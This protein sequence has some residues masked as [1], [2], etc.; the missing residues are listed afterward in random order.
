MEETRRIRLTMFEQEDMQRVHDCAMELLDRNGIGF[1]SDRAI[2]IFNEHGFR[3]D[4]QQVYFTE[5][6]VQAAL[7][8]C[9]SH[10]LLHGRNPKHT[11]DIGGGAYGVPGPIGPV[12][13]VSLDEDRHA[14]TFKDVENLIKIYQ[15]SDVINVNTNNGVEAN[16]IDASTRHFDIMK[17]VLKHS[18]KPFYTKCLDYDQLHQA[19][20][21]VEIATGEKL[22]PGGKTFLSSGSCPSL[23]PM[24]YS[25]EI[26]D[27]IIA[28]SERGQA[29]SFGNATTAGVTGPISIMGMTVMQTAELLSGIVL[30]QLVHPGT[31]VLFGTGAVPANMARATYCCGSPGRVAIELGVL[32]MGKRF[33]KLPARSIPFSTDST[34][35]DAQCLME[36]YEQL[37]GNTLGGADYMLSEIGTI[38]GLMT[39]SYEKTIL[40]EELVSRMLYIRDGI[41]VSLEACSVEEIIEVG[42]GGNFLMTEATIDAMYDAW[43]PTYTDWNATPAKRA[44]TDYDYVVKRANEEWKRRLEEAPESL[45]D[46]EVEKE[47]DAYIEAHK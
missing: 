46:S 4:G 47:L 24:A 8:T 44:Y 38:E 29:C 15:A 40:D 21:M 5:D 13:A 18:D 35:M 26:S 11:L 43:Y 33:Y 39:T 10:F 41:D 32:E 19:F 22:E 14:G 1:Y 45:L 31:P 17:A 7:A 9:P 20:D 23:S 25:S 34:S 27:F 16:D 28:L 42:S 3:T 6:Q 30:S 12:N 36:S 37:M 2:K